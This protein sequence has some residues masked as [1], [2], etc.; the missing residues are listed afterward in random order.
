MTIPGPEEG[1]SQDATKKVNMKRN[2]SSAKGSQPSK[3][4]KN[5]ESAASTSTVSESNIPEKNTERK[6]MKKNT[7]GKKEAKMFNDKHI[8]IDL[9]D[10][11]PEKMF[12]ERSV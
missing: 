3:K 10:S 11:D 12:P 2:K 8:D 5:K 7:A 9:F 4:V 6:R 1:G